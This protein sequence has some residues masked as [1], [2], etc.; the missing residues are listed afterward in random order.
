MEPTVNQ[1]MLPAVQALAFLGDAVHS[2]AVRMYLVRRGIATSGALNSEALEWVTAPRQAEAFRQVR[3]HLT[4]LE[5]DVARRAAN[6]SHLNRPKKVSGADYRQAT[7]YEAV[8]GLLAYLG[9]KARL[10]QVLTL[11]GF[12]ADRCPP[13]TADTPDAAA[14]GTTDTPDAAAA[15]AADTAGITDPAQSPPDA[16]DTPARS[17]T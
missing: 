11:S 6:S 10:E 17:T 7:A 1:C 12:P 4:E 5:A 8:L 14:A 15:G 2:M 16:P 13:S 9:D 3:E